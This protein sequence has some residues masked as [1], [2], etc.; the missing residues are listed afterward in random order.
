[1][2]KS[3]PAVPVAPTE[4]A[5][6]ADI[7]RQCAALGIDAAISREQAVY[8]AVLKIVKE[9]KR[10]ASNREVADIIGVDACHWT[11]KCV[12]LGTLLRVAPGRYIPRIVR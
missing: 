2:S 3:K 1:M 11:A 4:D 12:K 6:R 10:P 8:D 5:I 9:K 7:A